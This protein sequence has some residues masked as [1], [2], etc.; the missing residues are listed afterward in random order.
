MK[1]FW[2]LAL[3]GLS[4]STLY[5]QNQDYAPTY[6]TAFSLQP[7]AFLGSGLEI[8]VERKIALMTSLSFIAG[9]YLSDR[10]NVYDEADAMEGLKLELQPRFYVNGEPLNG[11]FFAPYALY[12]QIS[13]ENYTRFTFDPVTGQGQTSDENLS[14][15][16]GGL[17]AV[18]GVSTLV[19]ARLS[20]GVYGGGGLIIPLSDYEADIFHLTLVNPYRRGIVPRAGMSIGLAF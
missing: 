6:Q 12:R 7:F 8:N 20:I 13:L 10:P 14:A 1:F 2:I 18:F 4:A 19:G 11:V 5:A 17:G 15:Q 16:A 9:Y 3:F